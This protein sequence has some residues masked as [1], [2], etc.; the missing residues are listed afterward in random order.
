ML[1]EGDTIVPINT[2]FFIML[3]EKIEV[4]KKLQF[5]SE[6]IS[7]ESGFDSCPKSLCHISQK[8]HSLRAI[9]RLEI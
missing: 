5:A 4:F 7:D 8:V 6:R 2:W 9:S 1:Q 3:Q